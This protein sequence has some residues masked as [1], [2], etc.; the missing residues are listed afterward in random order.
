MSTTHT[1]HPHNFRI[2]HIRG[3]MPLPVSLVGTHELT[4][5]DRDTV[6]DAVTEAVRRNL[7]LAKS[8][9]V[10]WNPSG[11][12]V[13]AYIPMAGPMGKPG[14]NVLVATFRVQPVTR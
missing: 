10:R 2:G 13:L 9:S 12:Q 5:E 6:K 4:D 8:V 1:L 14:R 3:V 7:P 11:R